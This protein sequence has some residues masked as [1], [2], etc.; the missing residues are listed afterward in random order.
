[1]NRL[2]SAI[3]LYLAVAVTAAGL[4]GLG[5]DLTQTAYTAARTAQTVVL[6]PN[7]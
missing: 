5:V 1:M 6:V 3:P 4:I 7:T 2:L